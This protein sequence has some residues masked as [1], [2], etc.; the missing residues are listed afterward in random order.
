MRSFIWILSFLQ[1]CLAGRLQII[2]PN[3]HI[4]DSRNS[5]FDSVSLLNFNKNA[6]G[7]G[8]AP[9]QIQEHFKQQFGDDMIH[10]EVNSSGIFG[11]SLFK[12]NTEGN[13]ANYDTYKEDLQNMYRLS[14]AIMEK[15]RKNANV[16][17][18]YRV[19]LDVS[20]ARTD[21]E[22]KQLA[23]NIK[24]GIDTLQDAIKNSYGGNVVA[25]IYTHEKP[26]R[27][28]KARIKLLQKVL[29]V[30][31]ARYIDYPASAA[32]MMFVGF[33]LVFAAVA[34]LWLMFDES[35]MAKKTILVRLSMGRQKKD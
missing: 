30:T 9:N 17:D 26:D 21:M 4:L 2:L 24:R 7:L 31:Q 33:S 8:A 19:H 35:D 32:I 3:D 14:D 13:H 23:E 5:S 34:M 20:N 12:R 11:S 22:R 6:F 29:Q 16:V 1:V 28:E 18:Y 15:D 10:A 25:E 27:D